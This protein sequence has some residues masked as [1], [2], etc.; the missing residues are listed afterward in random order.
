MFNRKRQH[1][2]FEGD[3]LSR[4]KMWLDKGLCVFLGI[5]RCWLAL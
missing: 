2:A 1:F 3:V 5:G 4:S